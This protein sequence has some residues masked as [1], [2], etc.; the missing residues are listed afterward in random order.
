MGVLGSALWGSSAIRG[1][2]VLLSS[3]YGLFLTILLRYACLRIGVVLPARGAD[4]LVDA[5]LL[6]SGGLRDTAGLIRASTAEVP[7]VRY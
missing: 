4:A 3:A 1:R 6:W 5:A 7:L 2:G